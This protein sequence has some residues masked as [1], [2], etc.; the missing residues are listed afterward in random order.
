M[1]KLNKKRREQ[2]TK[3]ILEALQASEKEAFREAFL[4]LHPSDQS[5]VFKRLGK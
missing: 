2:Y 5:D 1:V 4:E 3:F